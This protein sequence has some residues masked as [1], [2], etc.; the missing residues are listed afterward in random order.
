MSKASLLCIVPQREKTHWHMPQHRHPENVTLG[1]E[2]RHKS[3]RICATERKQI[4]NCP[5]VWWA[6]GGGGGVNTVTKCQASLCTF[7]CPV[8]HCLNFTSTVRTGLTWGK[9]ALVLCT[10]F[11]SIL[12]AQSLVPSADS[13]QGPFARQEGCCKV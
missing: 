4:G 2:A 11:R 5:G 3:S 9:C 7:R 12:V 8:V 1:Q 10:L 6:G 13:M